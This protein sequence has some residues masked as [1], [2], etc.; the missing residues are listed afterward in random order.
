MEIKKGGP[1]TGPAFALQGQ[2]ANQEEEA[3]KLERILIVL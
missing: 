3:E 2:F 1:S